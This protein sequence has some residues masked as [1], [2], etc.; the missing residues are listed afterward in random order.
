MEPECVSTCLV[1][2]PS[3][4]NGFV[5]CGFVRQSIDPVFYFSHDTLYIYFLA[6]LTDIQTIIIGVCGGGGYVIRGRFLSL[7]C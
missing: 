6:V 1:T 5:S 2:S 3:E 7:G 4:R